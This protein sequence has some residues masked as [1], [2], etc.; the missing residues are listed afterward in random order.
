MLPD[1]LVSSG[2]LVLLYLCRSCHSFSVSH[3]TALRRMAATKGAS[4]PGSRQ[5]S[6][7]GAVREPSERY[8]LFPIAMLLHSITLGQPTFCG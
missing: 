8:H 5:V 2:P 6:E 4:A 3:A 1:I 7:A